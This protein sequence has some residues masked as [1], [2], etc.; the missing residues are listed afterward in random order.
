MSTIDQYASPR[1]VTAIDTVTFNE[2]LSE[3]QLRLA[4]TAG[5]TAANVAYRE[6]W[7]AAMA[8]ELSLRRA[9][10]RDASHA[11]LAADARAH[12]DLAKWLDGPEGRRL[13]AAALDR[14]D[15]VVADRLPDVVDAV[16]N[17]LT[18]VKVGA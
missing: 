4:F 2:G 16:V 17:A 3:D 7:S 1:V 12:A 13:V 8:R 9:A 11:E 10:I 15:A 6:G 14:T 5:F 18:T